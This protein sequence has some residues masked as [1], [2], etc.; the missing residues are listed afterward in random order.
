MKNTYQKGAL[1]VSIIIIILLVI[2]GGFYFYSSSKNKA[3][4]PQ[5]ES[6]SSTTPVGFEEI[7]SN[8]SGDNQIIS[9]YQIK[10]QNYA[11]SPATITIKKGELVIWTN[12]DSA[13]HTI[14][15]DTGIFESELLGSSEQFS[16]NFNQAGTFAYHCAIH[17]SMRATVIVT[18]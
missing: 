15:S 14:T 9:N 16:Q 1:S 18:E 5:S 13:P 12:N 10:I 2:V 11:F 3:V 17:P 8:L 6:Q 4:Q 7:P